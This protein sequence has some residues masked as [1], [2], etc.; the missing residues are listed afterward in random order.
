MAKT[1][2]S[3]SFHELYNKIDSATVMQN[4]NITGR[5]IPQP[6]YKTLDPN[7]ASIVLRPRPAD[8][9]GAG[10]QLS[11]NAARNDRSTNVYVYAQIGLNDLEQRISHEYLT[12]A[13]LLKKL[14]TD[15][16]SR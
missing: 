3:F 11:V 5:R 10:H 2:K 7:M 14:Q 8:G 12:K 1:G 15:Q 13:Q 4:N 16:I 9:G 6:Q